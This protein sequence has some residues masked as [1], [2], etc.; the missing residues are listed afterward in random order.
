MFFKMIRRVI[1]FYSLRNNYWSKL[2]DLT[3]VNPYDSDLMNWQIPNMSWPIATC[4]IPTQLWM[5]GH[6]TYTF[7]KPFL[8]SMI[9]HL[10]ELLC[11]IDIYQERGPKGPDF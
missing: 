8:F 9:N 10:T 6:G 4:S 3:E 2:D 7:L 1:W 11:K 5:N